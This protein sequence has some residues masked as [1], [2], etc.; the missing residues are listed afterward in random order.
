MPIDIANPGA[1]ESDLK[2]ALSPLGVVDPNISSV[3]SYVAA[4]LYGATPAGG[5]I[6]N[7]VYVSVPGSWVWLGASM[8]ESLVT[9][10]SF[11]NVVGCHG[12]FSISNWSS[13]TSLSCP[14]LRV[15]V[16]D[17]TMLGNDAV[18][19]VDFSAL[20]A[21]VG[22]MNLSLPAGVTSLDLGSL[23]ATGWGSVGSFGVTGTGT[24]LTSLDLSALQYSSKGV[25]LSTLG[26]T[27]MNLSSLKRIGNNVS[28]VGL[29]INTCPNLTSLNL[30]SLESIVSNGNSVQFNS[31]TGA[32]AT[33]TMPAGGVLKFVQNNWIMSS[34]ALS[35]QSVDDILVALAAL[36]GTGG[37]TAYSSKTVTLT[38]TSAAP[39]ATGATAKATLQGRS[40]TVN[41]N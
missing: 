26:I 15:I 35:Q 37:T 28:S 16:G 33:V 5:Y 29:Q 25:T 4:Q 30:S 3:G 23:V 20:E 14:A 13:L 32:L 31:G 27:S 17:M 9:S 10:L 19:S 18:T 7:G 41:T 22:R 24:S 34:C 21:V 39:S 36:D 6:L 8:N 1:S 38:G 2:T 11:N 12:D 40:C